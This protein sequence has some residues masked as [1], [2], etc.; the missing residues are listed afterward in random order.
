MVA[1]LKDLDDEENWRRFY[2]LY[3]SVIIG[4]A[5]RAGLRDDEAEVALQE[6][7]T[8]VSRSIGEFEAA[9]TR[10]SFHAWLLQLARQCRS[11]RFE[12]RRPLSLA[13]T[14]LQLPQ[15]P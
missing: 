11:E 2:Q 1:R 15:L 4:V 12:S 6:T 10:G 7:M 13:L 5:K 8:S 3:R 14:R 9:A